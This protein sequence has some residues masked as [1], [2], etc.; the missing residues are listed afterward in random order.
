MALTANDNRRVF[1][2][3]TSITFCTEGT[4]NPVIASD[5]G[6]CSTA[7]GVQSVGVTTTFNLEQVFE[8]GQIGIYENVEEV[9]D[10][11]VTIEK[12][13]DGDALLY[14][15]AT[16]GG[17]GATVN[18]VAQAN[19]RK[20]VYFMISDEIDQS[21]NKH[22]M[23]CYCSGMYVSSFSYTLPNEGNCTESITL[24][25][26]DKLWKTGG[27][28]IG[29]GV[30]AP[31]APREDENSPAGVPHTR[32]SHITAT[33]GTAFAN[34][35]GDIGSE[36]APEAGVGVQR[37][38]N[39]DLTLCILPDDIFGVTTNAAGGANNDF[40]HVN[41]ITVNGDLGREAINELGSKLPYYRY[42]TFPVEIGC[43]IEVT[44]VSGDLVDAGSHQD[45]LAPQNIKLVID[46]GTVWE[47]GTN[48]KLQSV[49]YTGASTGG[50]NA[51]VTYS[52]QG[53]NSFTVNGNAN[54]DNP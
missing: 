18:M 48:N 32:L 38:E 35:F 44:T 42:V 54:G 47:L 9:P 12:V 4:E 52:Y 8:L 40:V 50:E 20:D 53:F 10:I 46:D 28:H 33:Q 29:V 6:S 17:T 11:E 7:Y 22:G 14:D 21:V 51:T 43:D 15:L 41:S 16:L 25:G 27:K 24:V 23:I 36:D 2:A 49:T 30:N 31:F 13:L 45:N 26:N 19:V 3:C 37:R 39:V 34:D 1:W 5:P